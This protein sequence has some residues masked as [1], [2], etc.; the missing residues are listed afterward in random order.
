MIRSVTVLFFVSIFFFGCKSS[1][2]SSNKLEIAGFNEELAK[3]LNSMVKVDQEFIM[4]FHGSKSDADIRDLERVQDSI[5]QI[6][7]NRVKEIF[8]QYGFIGM[9]LAGKEGST[10]FWL[11]VQHSDVNPKF[12]KQVLRKM[13]EEV[14]KKN[15]NASQYGMLVDRMRVNS[16]K[17]QLY[18]TQVFYNLEKCQAIPKKLKDSSRVDNRRRELGLP[19]LKTYLN[20]MSRMHFQMNREN[21]IKKGIDSPTLYD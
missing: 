13:K 9:D 21:Y 1:K 12:Q 15:A 5:F 11:L 7:Y 17:K 18:G 20:Q 16:N 14:A 4:K 8:Y 10:S 2:I 3:E 6:N 19:D